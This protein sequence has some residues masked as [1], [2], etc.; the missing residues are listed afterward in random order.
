MRIV[1]VKLHRF[2][3]SVSF[4]PYQ[5]LPVDK[6][7]LIF[8]A[9]EVLC[10]PCATDPFP[11]SSSATHRVELLLIVTSKTLNLFCHA[12]GL[13]WL[14][15]RPSRA[16]QRNRKLPTNT[17]ATSKIKYTTCLRVAAIFVIVPHPV[18]LYHVGPVTTFMPIREL[19]LLFCGVYM[20][21]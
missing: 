6:T 21:C 20:L 12:V 15:S 8:I 9:R 10:I 11:C 1:V 16:P 2:W 5:L 3:T 18:V 19:Y 13:P 17:Y 4:M 7:I 14:G